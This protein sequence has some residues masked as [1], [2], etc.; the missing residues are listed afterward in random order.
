[1]NFPTFI[2]LTIISLC[3]IFS[4]CYTNLAKS[5]SS[6][7]SAEP[8]RHFPDENTSAYQQLKTKDFAKAWQAMRKKEEDCY[9]KWNSD[10]YKALNELKDRLGDG[11]HQLKDLKKYMGKPDSVLDD[12]LLEQNPRLRDQVFQ[13]AIPD[14]EAHPE[15]A[16]HLYFWRGWHDYVY[17]ISDGQQVVKADW[18]M[19][20]E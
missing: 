3:F 17:F 8:C 18:Y 5:S 16:Y 12:R 2:K 14:I 6:K 4:S 1:M 15:R 7:I 9:R 13:Q 20:Y 10:M 11:K 19:A